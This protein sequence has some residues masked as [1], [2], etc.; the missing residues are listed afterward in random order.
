MVNGEAARRRM[1]ER[2]GKRMR[3]G[4]ERMDE[5]G[6]ESIDYPPPN[7]TCALVTD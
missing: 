3:E 4:G 7:I 1:K 2:E 5:L 6:I